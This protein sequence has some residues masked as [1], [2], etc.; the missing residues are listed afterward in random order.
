MLSVSVSPFKA[1]QGN[2]TKC[3]DHVSLSKVTLVYI[4][5]LFKR[6]GPKPRAATAHPRA[7][8]GQHLYTSIGGT[9]CIYLYICSSSFAPDI[10]LRIPSM[11]CRVQGV[12]GEWACGVSLLIDVGDITY[13][14]FLLEVN[15]ISVD[16][17]RWL[18]PD[19]LWDPIMRPG[20]WV[21]VGVMFIGRYMPLLRIV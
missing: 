17:T 13:H 3:S 14:L 15:N 16:Q 12:G 18:N 2:E 4:L 10:P 8:L 9:Y 21:A 11:P 5:T 7:L 6:H 20:H 19:S 1:A